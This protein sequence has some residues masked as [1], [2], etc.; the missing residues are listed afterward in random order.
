MTTDTGTWEP[1]VD[2]WSTAI[3]AVQGS[4]WLCMSGRS[5]AAQYL[6]PS[7]N[8]AWVDAESLIDSYCLEDG[9]H[10]LKISVSHKLE[11]SIN[12]IFNERIKFCKNGT[13]SGVLNG[14][15]AL[16]KS[17]VH[18]E[19]IPI[20]YLLLI[21]SFRV[22]TQTVTPVVKS[23]VSLVPVPRYLLATK[24]I[25]VMDPYQR[26]RGFG[27]IRWVGIMKNTQTFGFSAFCPAHY[28]RYGTVHKLQYLNFRIFCISECTVPYEDT[29]EYQ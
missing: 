13:V 23:D 9:R 26:P 12:T 22:P 7:S 3:V 8:I 25:T 6:H 17:C 15:H 29:I 18:Y 20:P 2:I 1:Y 27:T 4:V 21:I 19:T 11:R 5:S 24:V 28:V 10:Y 16:P 14:E